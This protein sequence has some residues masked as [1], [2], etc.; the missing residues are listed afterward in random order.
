VL[1]QSIRVSVM[2]YVLSDIRLQVVY[3]GYYW[4]E[5]VARATRTIALCDTH[6]HTRRLYRLT[7]EHCSVLTPAVFRIVLLCVLG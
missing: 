3:C 6:T 4:L 5:T 2:R 1:R 7:L